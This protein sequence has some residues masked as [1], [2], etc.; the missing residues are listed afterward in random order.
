MQATATT[1]REGAHHDGLRHDWALDE[2]LAL[3]ALPFNDLL[4]QAHTIHR[5]NHDPNRIQ[6]SRLLSIKTGSCPEDCKYC[7]QS[8]HY[9]TGLEKEKLVEIETVL[10][11]AKAAKE[12]GAS[13]FCM[14]AAWRGPGRDFDSVLAM[15][16]GVKAMGLETCAS[17][18]LLTAEQAHQLKDAGLDYYNHNIDTSEEHYA[19]VI[20][21]R[22]FQDR[23]DTLETVRDA[24]IK[25]C[26]GGIVGLGEEK[27]DRAKMLMSL[28]NM[29]KHP[30][31]VPINLLIKIPGTPYEGN[32]GVDPFDFIRTI[33]VARIIMPKSLVRLSAGRQAMN[34][35]MQALCFFAGANSMFC[36]AKLLTA[37]NPEPGQDASLFGRL[38]LTP[39]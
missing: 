25:V 9:D 28:A 16:E 34:D 29:A 30:E 10:E 24:G 17:L 37:G 12:S 38:G 11:A 1:I 39:L 22:T 15:V 19:E 33:A 5:A 14:G 4:F 23:L 32:E 7:P 3:F 13:R 27:A 18:G 21:T 2:V 26:C 8:A 20:T 36:G 35:E 31:S 6:V